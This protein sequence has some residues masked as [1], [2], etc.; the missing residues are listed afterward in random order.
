[1]PTDSTLRIGDAIS[2]TNGYSPSH[3]LPDLGPQLGNL[4]VLSTESAT[5]GTDRVPLNEKI[6]FGIGPRVKTGREIEAMWK[7]EYASQVKADA[8]WSSHEP[9]RFA[10]EFWGV[11]GLGEK[12]R[13]YST[14]QFYAG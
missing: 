9:F 2:P 13:A 1:V 7:D 12:Q 8:M 6:F 14:T 3:T 4:S 10:V 11:A 5:S